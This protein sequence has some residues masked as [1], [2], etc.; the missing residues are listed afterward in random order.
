MADLETPW[1]TPEGVPEEAEWFDD[2]PFTHSG[3][4]FV[5]EP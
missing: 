4:A 5:G 1:A 3:E 2:G